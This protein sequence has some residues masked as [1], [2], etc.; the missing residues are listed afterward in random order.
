MSD[1]EQENRQERELGKH[2][3]RMRTEDRANLPPFPELAVQEARDGA[4]GKL[5]KTGLA[6]S[7]LIA[8]LILVTQQRQTEDPAL[9]YTEIMSIY[10][11]ETDD[12][13]FVSESMSPGMSRLPEIFTPA[14]PGA[15]ETMTN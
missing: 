2:F 13:L 5:L 3:A 12:L 6:A 7:V 14:I 9:L 8:S 15:S 1:S 10:A 4:R 11:M